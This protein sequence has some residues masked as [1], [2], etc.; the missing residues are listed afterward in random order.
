MLPLLRG[1]GAKQPRKGH[2]R[3][4]TPLS[5]LALTECFKALPPGTVNIV[6][7]DGE[8]TGQALVTHP[9]THVVAFTGSIT[10]GRKIALLCAGQ[11]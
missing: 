6:T 9:G 7:G 8:V 5:T 10:R 11:F 2:S 1:I 4:I 3:E